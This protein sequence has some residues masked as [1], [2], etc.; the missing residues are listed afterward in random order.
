MYGTALTLFWLKSIKIQIEK[1][2]T[3][4]ILKYMQSHIHIY[5]LTF[6]TVCIYFF[7]FFSF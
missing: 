2:H 3:K 4:H 7:N 6:G 5:K 1:Y